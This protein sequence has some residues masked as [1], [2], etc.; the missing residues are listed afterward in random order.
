MARR[1]LF[2][3]F[4][5]GVAIVLFGA[6]STAAAQPV[7]TA[8]A[9]P[10][11]IQLSLPQGVAF[12]YLGHSCGGIQ[13]QTFATGFDPTTGYPVGNVMMSTRC[14]G[15]GRDGGGHVTTYTAS[16]TAM[17]DFTGVLVTSSAPAT[18]TNDPNFTAFD[19]NGNEL[20]NSST[21]AYL[22]WSP[23]FV[24]VPRVLSISTAYGP[25][26]GGTPVTI[27]GTGFTNA[28]G[29]SFGTMPALFTITNDNSIAATAPVESAGTVDVIVASASGPSATSAADQFT[30]VAAP[31]ITKLDPNSGPLAGGG[32]TT[33]TGTNF[34]DV[35]GVNF[36]DQP[37]SFL[38]ND[39]TSIT[40]Y[41]P[42]GETPDNVGVSVTT[43]AG[44]T[45]SSAASQYTYLDVVV[46]PPPAVAALSPNT[47][48]PGGGTVVTITGVGFTGATDVSF[49]GAPAT[50]VT[51]NNDMQITATAPAGLGAVDVTVS[52][53]NGTSPITLADTFTYFSP[54]IT[55]ILPAGG[56]S[57]GGTK[58][59]IRGQYFSGA[60]DVSIGGVSA[61]SFIVNASGTTIRAITPPEAGVGAIAVDVTVTAAG[62]PGTLPASF[63]YFAPVVTR[64]GPSG[65]PAAGGRTVRIHGLH[66]YGAIEVLFGSTDAM[67]VKQ[68]DKSVTVIEPP[69]T[70]IVQVTV[71]TAAGASEPG[72]RTTYT[73]Q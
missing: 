36:G 63:T 10:T 47:G 28:T 69:G 22:R 62:G 49:G 37:T 4:A 17:W 29:V 64:V 8:S 21:R 24:P 38:V 52:G 45:P 12:G 16:V 72:I 60:T 13:E 7:P 19:T 35:S 56:A 18:G 65:G 51:V 55:S 39:A 25:A 5:A 43:V 2:F 30:F 48:P 6:V 61:T 15:S 40:A 50:M 27:T 9:T 59:V 23:T 42:G 70:G 46:P 71:V 3:F 68:T 67:I 57:G 34:V 66:L 54:T 73:Y 31:T 41:I 11:P 44:T 58:V 1:N 20:Y 33:I 26:A 14:G 32:Y 53:P